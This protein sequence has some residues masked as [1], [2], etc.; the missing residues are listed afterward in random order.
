MT[1]SALCPLQIWRVSITDTFVYDMIYNPAQDFAAHSGPLIG[2][3]YGQWPLD[4][5]P[6]GALSFNL[7]TDLPAPIEVMRTALF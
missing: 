4:A 7:W 1:T 2:Y 5:T 6:P 3:A